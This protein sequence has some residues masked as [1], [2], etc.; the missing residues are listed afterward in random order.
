MSEN[1]QEL[2][3]VVRETLETQGVLNQVRAKIRAEVYKALEEEN[4]GFKKPLSSENFILN[5]LILEYLSF[6]GYSNASSVLRLESGQPIERIDRE[7]L[8]QQLNVVEDH[9]KTNIPL[10]YSLV[11]FF[12]HGDQNQMDD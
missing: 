1:H 7:F 9:S 8:R 12:L 6:N 3:E 10:L 5:E 2:K 4:S 11:G